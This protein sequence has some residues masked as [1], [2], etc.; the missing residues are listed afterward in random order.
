MLRMSQIF[1]VGMTCRRMSQIFIVGMTCCV[2]EDVA[3]DAHGVAGY[4]VTKKQ[5]G[6]GVTYRM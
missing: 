3:V 5:R 4:N 2:H 1:I 6:K